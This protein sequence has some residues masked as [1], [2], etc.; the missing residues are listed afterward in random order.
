MVK[1]FANALLILAETQRRSLFVF[2]IGFDGYLKALAPIG[3]SILAEIL[4][5][6]GIA[7]RK[8]RDKL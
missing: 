1:S 5:I 3:A 4:R 7:S 2:K 6:A 8:N